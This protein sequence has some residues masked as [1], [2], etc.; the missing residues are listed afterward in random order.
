M[1]MDGWYGRLWVEKREMMRQGIQS[2]EIGR[3]VAFVNG[4]R[5][6]AV[7]LVIGLFG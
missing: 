2:N 6:L 1:R 5:S 3:R 4:L 7:G